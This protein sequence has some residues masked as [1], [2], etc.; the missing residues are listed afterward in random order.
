M[1][2]KVKKDKAKKTANPIQS[3]I[4][5]WKK[6]DSEKRIFIIIVAILLVFVFQMPNIYHGWV[7]FRDNGFKFSS[8]KETSG[9]NTGPK[10]DPNAG[11]TLTMTCMQSVQDQKYNT[12]VKTEIDYVDSQ[13]KKENYQVTLESLNDIGKEELI[14]RQS[15]YQGMA[16]F[17]NQYDGMSGKVE[18]KDNVLSYQLTTDYIKINRGQINSDAEASDNGTTIALKANQD[19]DEVKSYYENLGLTCRK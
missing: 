19:I 10:K 4:T 1:A 15:L 18:V 3:I 6:M 9:T 13:L 7:N 14:E 16:D 5:S 17:L 8:K 11:K 2:R 12:R